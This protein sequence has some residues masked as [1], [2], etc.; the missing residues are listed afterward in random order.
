[1]TGTILIV[2]DVVT[3]RIVL[4]V[5]LVAACYETVQAATGAEALRLAAS[6]I[7][8]LI[9]LDIG[10]PDIDGIT[11][12]ERLRACVVTRDIPII[13][14]TALT[15]MASKI[16]ALEVG[17]D[18][19]L[20][21]PMDDQTLLARVR[22]LL[23]AREAEAELRLR[24]STCR[25]LGFAEP[26][27]Q[28]QG[29][30]TIGLIAAARET[31]VHWRRAIAPYSRNDMV[32]MGRAEALSDAPL[33]TVPDVFVIACDLEHPGDGLRL[34]S[35]L[36]SRSAT[37]HSA[38][39]IVLRQDAETQA[40]MALDLGANDL[41]TDPFDAQEMALRLTT[42]VRRKRLGDQLRNAV[43]DGL[44]LAVADPLTG[45]Y[46]RRYALPHLARIADRA[47]QTGKPFAVM[48]VDLDRFKSVNDRFGHAAGDA[49]LVEAARRLRENL[50]SVDLLARIG[51]EEFL[52][53][54]PDTT[55]DEARAAAQRLCHVI[56][57]EPIPMPESQEPI[58]VTAS[59]GLAIGSYR[60]DEAW[61]ATEITGQADHA[62][63]EAKS[64]GRNQVTTASAA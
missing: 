36:R 62:L 9:L 37:R 53:A 23:R 55:D 43:R 64:H 13:M 57:A 50:R 1:M 2:D 7:P 35:D 48:V 26:T 54:M 21:K 47:F 41:L 8:D 51:G 60:A 42:L 17:A 22:S 46:N 28:F 63:L 56:G 25:E 45:L 59:I 31:S 4:K 15:D 3:N 39:C 34:M 40:A 12:C 10:L 38:V 14:V 24:E 33:A 49:V 44:R 5:K 11:V 58:R 6:V 27:A 16:R 18:E 52:V 61:G 30:A 29:R 19:F 20:S 32:V